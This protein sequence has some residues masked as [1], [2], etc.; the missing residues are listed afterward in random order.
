MLKGTKVQIGS[1]HPIRDFTY[2]SDTVEGFIK[3]AETDGINGKVI[4][5]GSNQGIS[6]GDLTS[7]LAKI[8]EKEVT[9]EC[10]E[11]RVR[12]AHSEVNRLICDNQKAQQL[13]GWQPMVHLEEGLT[14]TIEWFKKTKQAYKSDLY[15]I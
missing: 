14:K 10:E 9:I 8:M 1:L 11:E 3:A 4:N 12:P 2:V 13:I 15:N 7:T 5:L 6:I